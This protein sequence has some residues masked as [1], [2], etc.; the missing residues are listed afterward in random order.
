MTQVRVGKWAGIGNFGSYVFPMCV[1]DYRY[2]QAMQEAVPSNAT[3]F[4]CST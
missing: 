1:V 2:K 4:H 3:T